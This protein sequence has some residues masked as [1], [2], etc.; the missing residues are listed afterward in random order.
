MLQQYFVFFRRSG[1]R[2]LYGLLA[3]TTALSLMVGTP[4]PARAIPWWE[5]LLRGAQIFQ[6]SNM[7]DAQEVQLGQQINQQVGARLDREGT[8]LSN[9]RKATEYFDRIGQR[10]AA[11]SDR[12]EIPYKFQIVEDPGIN[13]FAT[14]GGFVYINAGLMYE[15]ENEAELAS[16]AAHEIGHIVG[17]HA[18]KQMR[19]RAIAEGL[20]SAAGLDQ[21]TAVQ[22]GVELALNL[23]HSRDDEFEA[24]RIG[25]E[26]LR[27][28]G[29]APSGAVSFMQKLQNS[30]GG[31]PPAFLSTHPNVGDRISILEQLL[32]ENPPT[33]NEVDGLDNVAYRNKLRSFAR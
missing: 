26:I 16:V 14:M 6:L 10:L 22:L 4:Q 11:A 5:I 19:Q 15:A 3:V 23:P 17:R 9:H 7:S 24:D 30:R 2:W 28:A 12:A 20:L 31:S 27:R 29:Y 33:A 18:I 21:S 1:R 8:P 13:A 32:Q 25:L